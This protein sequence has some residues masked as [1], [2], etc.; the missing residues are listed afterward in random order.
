MT[1]KLALLKSG[2]DVIADVQEMILGEEP[3]QKVVGYIF[4]K[5]CSIKMRVREEDS[6]K[7]KTDSV[8]IRLTPWIIL[9]K[10]TKIPVSLDWVITLV[11]PIDQLLK[12]YEEDI[13]NN[14]K[15]N[16]SIVAHQ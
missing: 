3:N 7:E 10:D 16:Q 14:E 11:D 4:N 12:M 6:D 2:E 5:P 13:L 9:T 1:V 8:K 15:S